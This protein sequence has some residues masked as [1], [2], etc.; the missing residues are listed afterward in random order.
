MQAGMVLECINKI[1]WGA[2]FL[3]TFIGIAVNIIPIS[4]SHRY[5]LWHAIMRSRNWAGLACQAFYFPNTLSLC[6][7]TTYTHFSIYLS[8]NHINVIFFVWFWWIVYFYC[9]NCNAVLWTYICVYDTARTLTT[10]GTQI[11]GRKWI[12]PITVTTITKANK[13]YRENTIF[14]IYWILCHLF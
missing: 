14:Q 5:I 4:A 9:W 1:F 8:N 11:W 7:V 12:I 6:F 13:T 3:L 2:V 10:F